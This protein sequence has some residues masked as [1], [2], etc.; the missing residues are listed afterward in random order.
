VG[1]SEFTVPS[2]RGRTLLFVWVKYHLKQPGSITH[3]EEYHA[4]VIASAMHP[5]INLD[6]LTGF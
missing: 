1:I 5:T 3:V 6:F 2:G 4:T